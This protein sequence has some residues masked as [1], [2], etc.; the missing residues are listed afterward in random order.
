MMPRHEGYPSEAAKFL[1]RGDAL[2]RAD[3]IGISV[4]VC[5]Y[6]YTVYTVNIYIYIYTY[7]IYIHIITHNID[8]YRH[9]HL[10]TYIYIV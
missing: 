5:I 8:K 1:R 7:S 3:Y 9:S 4:Y 6:I 10:R 2:W